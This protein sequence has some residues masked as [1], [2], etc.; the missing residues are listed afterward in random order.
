MRTGA[1]TTEGTMPAT[2]T[3][4]AESNQMQPK[5]GCPE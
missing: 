2:V 4:Y 5:Q 3:A 1:V